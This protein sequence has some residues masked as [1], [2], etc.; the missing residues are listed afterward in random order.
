MSNME[1][2]N[3]QDGLKK[4]D[5]TYPD[6]ETQIYQYFEEKKELAEG[7]KKILE[8]F[9]TLVD[10]TIQYALDHKLTIEETLKPFEQR[11]CKQVVQVFVSGELDLFWACQPLAEIEKKDKYIA[12]NIL[13]LILEQYILRFNKELQPYQLSKKEFRKLC[14]ELQYFTDECIRRQLH[15]IA[16][17]EDFK[18][19]SGLSPEVC[20]QFIGKVDAN[21]TDLK[22][23][24]I[25][26]ELGE[27][28]NVYIK[29]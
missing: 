4:M 3:V 8:E 19:R 6:W 26:D 29:S 27:M 14:V 10:R 28:K 18:R 21:W 20:R 12:E 7:E 11:K 5:N 13:D 24:Y 9:R 2:W 15:P 25:I 17:E 16:M 23:N 1:N 22:L